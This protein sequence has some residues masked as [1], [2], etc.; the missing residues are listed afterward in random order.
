MKTPGLLLAIAMAGVT[1]HPGA[2]GCQYDMQCK[3]ERICENAQCVSPP[4]EAPTGPA[5][6]APVPSAPKPNPVSKAPRGVSPPKKI[7]TPPAQP[8]TPPSTT[9]HVTATGQPA[10]AA[11]GVKNAAGREQPAMAS[12]AITNGPA[13]PPDFRYCCTKIG[14]FPLDG[15]SDAEDET[16]HGTTNDG[17]S[18]PGKPCN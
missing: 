10:K 3:G 17:V 12:P 2:V 14:K 15:E 7:V 16:C 9:S 6:M 13:V 8:T 5:T 4:E 1:P 18:L 11:V